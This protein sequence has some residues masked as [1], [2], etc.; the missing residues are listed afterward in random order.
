MAKAPPGTWVERDLYR[1]K[2][3]FALRGVAAQILINFLG[4]RNFKRINRKKKKEWVCENCNELTFTYIEAQ[5][6]FG[7]SKARFTRAIDE[8]LAKGFI[9]INHHGGT[10]RH[11]KTIFGLC[12]TWRIWAP[13]TVL[14]TRPKEPVKRG[15]CDPERP[16][17]TKLAHIGAPIH[18]HKNEPI[19]G[20][21]GSEYAP[22]DFH[23]LK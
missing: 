5:K 1:S 11:D 17:K 18:A 15:Y 8:L 20:G 12:D 2:A 19:P 9:T 3:F 7:V 21:L 22:Q 4:K 10:Y 6:N 16:G 13:G 23:V 14:D